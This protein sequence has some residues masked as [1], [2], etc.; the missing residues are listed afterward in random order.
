MGAPKGHQQM[1]GL[2]QELR[3]CRMLGGGGAWR[4]TFLKSKT[5]ELGPSGRHR[6]CRSIV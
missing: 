5:T 3:R 6:I 2:A 1:G 4:G